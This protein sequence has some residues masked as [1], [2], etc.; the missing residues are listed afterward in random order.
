MLSMSVRSTADSVLQANEKLKRLRSRLEELDRE[1]AAV[2]GEIEAVLKEIA[3]AAS[4]PVVP[5]S[6]PATTAERIL[7]TLEANP[8]STFT[9][10]DFARMWSGRG[11]ATLTGFRSALTIL[12][13]QG[14]IRRVR[15][16]RYTSLR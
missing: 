3:S 6:V 10:L 12:S 14:K 2:E 16:G 1:R 8:D 13:A 15:F 9:A 11:G 5:T 7:A 4:T